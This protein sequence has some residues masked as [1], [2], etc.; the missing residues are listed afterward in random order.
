VAA[1][2]PVSEDRRGCVA[3]RQVPSSEVSLRV[4]LPSVELSRIS[5]IVRRSGKFRAWNCTSV[6]APVD[7]SPGTANIGRVGNDPAIGSQ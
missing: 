5:G 1:L 7:R 3:A 4:P 6:N 2:D